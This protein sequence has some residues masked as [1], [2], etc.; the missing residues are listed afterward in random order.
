M[1]TP[2]IDDAGVGIMDH[3]YVYI[4]DNCKASNEIGSSCKL[5][6]MTDTCGDSF[7]E[8]EFAKYAE[9][10][11]IVLLQGCIGPGKVDMTRYPQARDIQLGRLDVFGQ[12][13]GDYAMQSAPHMK[14]AGKL[15]RHIS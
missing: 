14:F 13:S 10:N 9:S 4:P 6:M 7:G 1:G 2:F 3:G 11:D 8:V 15:L 5:I 12:L